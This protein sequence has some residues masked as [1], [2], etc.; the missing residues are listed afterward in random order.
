VG[1][2]AFK[3]AGTCFPDHTAECGERPHALWRR[4]Q[5]PAPPL[6][7]GACERSI[8]SATSARWVMAR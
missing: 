8:R 7:H 1:A 2:G 5:D 3:L 6:H 4:R